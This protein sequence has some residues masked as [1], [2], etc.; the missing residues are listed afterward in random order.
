MTPR[1][2][3]LVIA[4]ALVAA[5][6]AAGPRK[7]LVLPVDGSADAGL[8]T[9]LTVVVQ[10]VAKGIPG[11]VTNGDT[12]FAETA[13]AVG[14]DSN[15]PACVDTVLGTL[16]VDEVVWGTATPNADGSTTLVVKRATKGA[17]PH[18]QTAIITRAESPDVA[19]SRIAPLF[20]ETSATA[21]SGSAA[22]AAIDTPAGGSAEA[23]APA[24]PWS[25]QKKLG[26]GLAV[27]GGVLI[28]AGLA[29]W[30]SESGVQTDINNAP[31]RTASDIQALKDLE[32]K[33]QGYAWGGNIAM[34]LGLGAGG[35]GAYL[36]W[37]DHKEHT[38]VTPQPAP[39]G[40]ITFMLR[41]RW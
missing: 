31:D 11:E 13:S 26:I 39:G 12:T 41:G 4:L 5:S 19:T 27:G 30:S 14:C 38:I 25:D 20:P 10:G 17:P 8:R 3:V 22:I 40:G 1:R 18:E 15:R 29:L 33:A 32:S 36:L 9:K 28:V 34:V 21:G 35:Y 6:V 16:G 24:A 7:V 2:L 37:K 23:P